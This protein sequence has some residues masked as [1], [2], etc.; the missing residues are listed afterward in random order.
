MFYNTDYLS[1]ETLKWLPRLGIHAANV[2]PEFGVT[3]SKAFLKTLENNGLKNIANLDMSSKYNAKR[4]SPWTSF[5]S[6]FS[7]IMS[8]QNRYE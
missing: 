1:N 7:S 5:N 2:A 6:L 3:E 4:S 8:W